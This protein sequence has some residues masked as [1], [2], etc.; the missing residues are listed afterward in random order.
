MG[1]GVEVAVGSLVGVAVAV[2]VAVSVLVAV[3]VA[4]GRVVAVLV[5]SCVDEQADTG[6][7]TAKVT[8]KKCK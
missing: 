3:A 5:L 4:L 2:T 8:A 1:P 7:K 6:H